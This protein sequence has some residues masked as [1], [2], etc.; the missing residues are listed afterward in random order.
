MAAAASAAPAAASEATARANAAADA[1]RRARDW[2]HL[3]RAAVAGLLRALHETLALA[4]R[5]RAAAAREALD[6]CA[7]A[8]A[9]DDA[10][11]D[12]RDAL[13]RR[14]VRVALSPAD[15]ADVV[16]LED[17]PAD[18]GAAFAALT[19]RELLDAR[20]ADAAAARLVELAE[21]GAA[22]EG[23]AP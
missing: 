4:H 8:L 10:A 1:A 19:E 17:A 11:D 23:G 18:E 3:Y 5:A 15:G 16:L 22:R 2:A 13:L 14:A 20:A 21:G 6:A 9:T 12:D 7:P